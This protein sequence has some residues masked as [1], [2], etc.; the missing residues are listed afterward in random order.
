[1]F[2]RSDRRFSI[3]GDAYDLEKINF[4]VPRG[5]LERWTVSADMMMHPFHVHGVKFQVLSE[6]GRTPQR[7]NTGWKD[8]VLIDGSADLLIRFDQLAQADAPFMYHCHILEHEDSGMMGQFT[9]G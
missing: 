7:H 4:H 1:M 3:N 6:N 8:T 5:S 2:G 9:V